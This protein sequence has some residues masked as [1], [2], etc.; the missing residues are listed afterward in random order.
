LDE[1]GEF[2][3]ELKVPPETEAEQHRMT[4]TL[5]ALDRAS[6]L[7]EM[8][9]DAGAPTPKNDGPDELRAAELCQAAMRSAQA[10]AASITAESALSERALPIG[11]HTTPEAEAALRELASAAKALDDMQR[12]YRATTLAAVA[13]GKLNASEAF[14]RVDA[15]RRLDEIAHLAW[16]SAAHLLGHGA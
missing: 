16:R 13:P 5:H 4:S 2:L 10:V 9:R 14:D 3:S 15:V 7:A 12:A 8:L 1:A 11:W 6:R